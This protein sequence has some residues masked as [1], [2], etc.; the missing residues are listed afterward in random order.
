MF[1]MMKGTIDFHYRTQMKCNSKSQVVL[2][3]VIF[4]TLN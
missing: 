1:Q 2:I 3:N 4:D